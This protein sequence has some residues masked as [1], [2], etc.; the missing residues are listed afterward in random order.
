MYYIYYMYYINIQSGA[1]RID[2]NA[3]YDFNLLEDRFFP[4]GKI[5]YF[6]EWLNMF[7]FYK[8]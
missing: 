3:K 1:R 5:Y 4:R 6:S 8:I 2:P 7:L